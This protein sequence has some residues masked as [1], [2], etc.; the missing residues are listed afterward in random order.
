MYVFCLESAVKRNRNKIGIRISNKTSIFLLP[1]SI[2][3][4]KFGAWWRLLL[5]LSFY[6]SILFVLE[7]V[8]HKFTFYRC[9]RYTFLSIY[10]S[11]IYFLCISSTQQLL[12]NTVFIELWLW[13]PDFYGSSSLAQQP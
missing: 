4:I 6:L 2:N 11:L 12:L 9:F 10:S 13:F 5:R 1:E 8:V 3:S 7:R